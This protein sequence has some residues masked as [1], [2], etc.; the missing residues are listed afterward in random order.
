[1]NAERIWTDIVSGPIKFIK[2]ARQMLLCCDGHVLIKIPHDMCWR[3]ELREK[4]T[5]DQSVETIDVETATQGLSMQSVW[6][7]FLNKFTDRSDYRT[8][9]TD[10]KQYVCERLSAKGW[11]LLW[12]KG[13][14]DEQVDKYIDFLHSYAKTRSTC[15]G[16]PQLVIEIRKEESTY[17]DLPSSVKTIKWEDYVKPFDVLTFCNVIVSESELSESWK[18]YLANLCATVCGEDAELCACLLNECIDDLRNAGIEAALVNII[19]DGEFDA[20]GRRDNATPI[21]KCHIL[22]LLRNG[23][24]DEIK[25]RIRVAQTMSIYPLL[26]LKRESLVKKYETD[27]RDWLENN[28]LKQ[29][30]IRIVD[31]FELE[32]GSIYYLAT[33]TEMEEKL[34]SDYYN[35]SRLRRMRNALAHRKSCDPK[36]ICELLSEGT[37]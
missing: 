14:P 1:M 2:E 20:R 34:S 31:P 7:F 18:L 5:N 17:R 21:N 33:Q 26:E 25:R 23:H 22:Y 37:T 35:V 28:E 27:L 13:I 19:E 15:K 32:I 10:I 6:E 12:L 3:E 30:K 29:N 24:S 8:N 11:K 36:D 16:A 4:I 9:K